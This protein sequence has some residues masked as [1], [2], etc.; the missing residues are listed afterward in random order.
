MT[1][2][3]SIHTDNPVKDVDH[4]GYAV[5]Y[6]KIKE[7]IGQVKANGQDIEV[8]EN[9][10]R[11]RIQLFMGSNP[12]QFHPNQYKIQMT[13]WES[14]LA[15]AKWRIHAKRYNEFWTANEW[16]AAG[17]I[18]AGVPPQMVHV[19]GHLSCVVM[20]TR[21]DSYTLTQVVLESVLTLPLRLSRL[22]LGT[23]QTMS[24]PLSMGLRL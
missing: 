23:T 12:G 8:H 7:T 24:L 18:N 6:H 10:K 15:P 16:G 21:F 11:A 3:F 22:P 14:T 13:Q 1:Y 5:A 20:A 4:F 19:S 9:D 17:I 2:I